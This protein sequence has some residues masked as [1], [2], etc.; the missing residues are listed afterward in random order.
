M[1][2]KQQNQK[3]TSKL[4]KSRNKI[5][6]QQEKIENEK[7]KMQKLKKSATFKIGKMILW[8]PRKVFKKD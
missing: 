7:E 2:M 8:L 5:K 3:L 4:E 6:K 1:D